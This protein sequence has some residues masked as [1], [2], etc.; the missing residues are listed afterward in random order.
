[1]AASKPTQSS[2]KVLLDGACLP[3]GARAYDLLIALV[4]IRDRV[5]SKDCCRPLG[6]ETRAIDVT[7]QR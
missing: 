6:A 5:V 1:L 7:P 3:L 4:D 2:A